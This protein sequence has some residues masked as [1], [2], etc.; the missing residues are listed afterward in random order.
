VREILRGRPAQLVLAAAGPAGGT[1]EIA[2]HRVPACSSL[3]GARRGDDAELR[4]RTV[5]SVVLDDVVR[6]RRLPTPFVL[7]IDVEGAELRVLEGAVG[8][9]DQTELVLL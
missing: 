3:L 5:P 4:W 2:V 9:L 1:V 6:E 8:L 7:K